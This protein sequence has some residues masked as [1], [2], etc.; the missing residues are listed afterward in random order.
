[1]KRK[2]TP[3]L[4]AAV[5]VLAAVAVGVQAG[6]EDSPLQRSPPRLVG[7][8][9]GEPDYLPEPARMVVKK[10]MARHG[11]DVSELLFA[12]TLLRYDQAA[13]AA[14]RIA[15]EPRFVRPIVGG[16]GDL[17]AALP[18]RFFVLQDEARTR[19]Q[20]LARA[21]KAKDDRALA[22]SFGRLTETCVGCH[23]AYLKP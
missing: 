1:M 14:M 7:E 16:E 3:G 17:N 15:S 12:V 4:W 8:P 13:D 20:A 19:A 10:K 22:Q 5:V 9:L 11:Q 23:S 2:E 18:E 21:A 6:A